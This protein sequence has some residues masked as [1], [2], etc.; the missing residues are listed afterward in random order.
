MVISVSLLR[1]VTAWTIFC[2]DSEPSIVETPKSSG[3]VYTTD[4]Q[5]RKCEVLTLRILQEI[6][7]KS[8]SIDGGSL[9][10]ET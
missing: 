1:S 6:T 10:G 5:R 8:G 4:L 7:Q 2:T 9:E 3:K